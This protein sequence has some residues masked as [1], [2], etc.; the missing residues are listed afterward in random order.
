MHAPETHASGS[1]FVRLEGMAWA[2]VFGQIL[3][4]IVMSL[5]LY[6]L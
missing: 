3:Q 2:C 6:F 4:S 1:G 5:F